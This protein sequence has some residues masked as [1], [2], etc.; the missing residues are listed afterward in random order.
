[1][2]LLKPEVL[3][4]MRS[5]RALGY[6]P[7][8]EERARF[9]DQMREAY[10]AGPNDQ[11]RN[12]Q[13][14]GST[15]Q[16]N[17][18]GVLTEKPD[19]FALLFGGGNTTYESI[20]KALALADSD[21]SV[22][23]AVLYVSSPGGHLDG[24]FE[25]FASLDAFSKPLRVRASLAAS[26]AYGLAAV[27]GPIEAVTPASEF[28]SIGVAASYF[29]DNE[30]VDIASTDAP[31]KRPDMATDEGKAVVREQLDALHEQFAAAI[32]RG[33][34]ATTGEDVTVKTV[35]AEFGQGGMFIAGTAQ[36]RGMIDKLAKQPKRARAGRYAAETREPSLNTEEI[37]GQL[38]AALRKAAPELS[39]AR[40]SDVVTMVL[41]TPASVAAAPQESSAEPTAPAAA[42]A[43]NNASAGSGGA[44]P[45]RKHMTEAELRAQHPELFAA[46]DK[47][48]EEAVKSGKA[49][50]IKEGAEQE[51]KRCTDHLKVGTS[52]GDIEAAH[53]A[54]GSGASLNDM[55]ADYMAAAL[56]RNAIADR[57]EETDAAGAAANGAKPKE[58]KSGRDAVADELDKL[59]SGETLA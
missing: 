52:S 5:A 19:C 58:N 47:K 7:T 1:M 43:P 35:N 11:P 54:I 24:L 4:A 59:M 56:K 26:A 53:K 2:W 17:V 31:K 18:E 44:Q 3:Q 37:A 45:K 57:Q 41:G 36:K 46:L 16:I 15:A 29:L 28:G 14:A 51:R 40:V 49:D 34:S 9:A 33:R 22:K 48:N 50:G 38:K 6:E 10:A 55:H 12:M 13:V 25:T 20:R 27:A 32:A 23:D 42:P 30:I 21:P 39:T 8:L